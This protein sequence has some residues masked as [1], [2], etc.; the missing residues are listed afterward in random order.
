MKGK[1]SEIPE[2]AFATHIH[3]TKRISG[4]SFGKSGE[5]KVY[6]VY[7]WIYWGCE[8]TTIVKGMAEKIKFQVGSSPLCEDYVLRN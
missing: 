8:H 3:T 1:G 5:S 2:L 7:S 6:A 4:F